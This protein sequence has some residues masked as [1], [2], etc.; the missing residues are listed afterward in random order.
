MDASEVWKLSG[1]N[2][3]AE[4]IN[5]SNKIL[6]DRYSLAEP[7]QD[8]SRNEQR[9]SL[10]AVHTRPGAYRNNARVCELEAFRNVRGRRQSLI[11]D[12]ATLKWPH[13]DRYIWPHPNR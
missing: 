11:D 4:G 12:F 2:D 5:N 8:L 3:R 7:G 9:L 10:R 13:F 1:G 6:R